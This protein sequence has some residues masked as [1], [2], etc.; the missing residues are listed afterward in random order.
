MSYIIAEELRKSFGDGE[1]AVHAVSGMNFKIA[2][3]EF[4]AIMGESGA[5][6]S[7]LLG[8]LGAMNA[9][10]SGRLEVDGID[11]YRLDSDQL[12]DF[13][14]EYLGFVFQSF[15]LVPYLSVIENVMLPLAVARRGNSEKRGMARQALAQVGLADK[16]G[17]L[18]GE[19]SG[20]EKERVAVARAIVNEPPVLLADEPTGNL[21]SKNSREIMRMFQRLNDSGMTV[22]MVTHSAECAGYARRVMQLC[23]GRLREDRLTAGAALRRAS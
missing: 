3:G 7:T 11:V 18:P 4:V 19:I 17:R 16:A 20:G 15:H 1:T 10:T 13:R 12:A 14:R 9:P 6:K 8:M 21:D 22:I 5:G 2:P 23:D